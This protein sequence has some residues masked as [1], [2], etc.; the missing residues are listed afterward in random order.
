[1]LYAFQ[2][3]DEV[4]LVATLVASTVTSFILWRLGRNRARESP[5]RF[6]CPRCL[7]VFPSAASTLPP[8]S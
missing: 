8:A 1:L 3:I 4:G 2:P 6:A 7:R 5:E